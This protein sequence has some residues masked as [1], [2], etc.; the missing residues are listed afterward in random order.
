MAFGTRV[1]QA[2]NVNWNDDGWNV[3]ANSVTNPNEWNDG[4]QVFSRN[5]CISPALPS[6]SFVFNTLY[7]PAEH[8]ADF[9][10]RFRDLRIFF[11]IESF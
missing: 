4:N 10:Q 11:S 3:N 6:G 1:L 7:P 9:V 2:V 5:C 8:L